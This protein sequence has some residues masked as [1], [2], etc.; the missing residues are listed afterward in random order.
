MISPRPKLKPKCLEVPTKA[1]ASPPWTAAATLV[2]IA[3]DHGT[4]AEL[5]TLAAKYA[6]DVV[7]TGL[8][9][10]DEKRHRSV[11]PRLLP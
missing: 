11:M 3:I 9:S 5:R 7:C 2:V 10:D 1:P 6:M 8:V 4:E